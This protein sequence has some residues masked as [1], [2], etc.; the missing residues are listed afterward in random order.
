MNLTPKIGEAPTLISVVK[1]VSSVFEHAP[2]GVAVSDANYNVVYANESLMA[3]IG[4]NGV[5][6]TGRNL[7]QYL[8]LLVEPGQF[9]RLRKSVID[10]K[11]YHGEFLLSNQNKKSKVHISFVP[12]RES[13]EFSSYAYVLV[14]GGASRAESETLFEAVSLDRM[15]TRGE[16]AAEIAHEINNYLT[17]L[18]GNVELI[19]L[20]LNTNK[21]EKLLEKSE[22][23]RD[24]LVKISKFTDCLSE[25][26]KVRDSGVEYCDL[27]RT[28]EQ[29]IAFLKPQNRFDDI[30]IRA[31]LASEP[32]PI[33]AH[34]GP[35]QQIIVS[36]ANNAADE[37]NEGCSDNPVIEIN[38]RL[39]EDGKSS[40]LTVTD[41]G[42][43][44][45]AH[46]R[47]KIFDFRVSCRKNGEGFGLLACKHIVDRYHGDISYET[48]DNVGTTFTVILPKADIGSQIESE[49]AA[50]QAEKL[51]PQS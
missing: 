24:T 7:L 34:Q 43:G 29:M 12:L 42:R 50:D 11:P 15:L 51:T 2:A 35:I 19:P 21:T 9:E 31:D 32:L 40:I 17:I 46:I 5:S 30:E 4:T 28:V 41:N 37:L 20:F 1:F 26:G 14:L 27:S 3:E 23:M 47:P 33:R 45:P 38:T 39:S 36:L 49:S 6:I 25:F 10:E 13:E 48:E 22:L 16:M 44:I 18:L 8:Q